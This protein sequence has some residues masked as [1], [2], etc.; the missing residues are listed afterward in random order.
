MAQ[1][2]LPKS[3]DAYDDLVQESSLGALAAI[4]RFEP[5]RGYKP[6]T[7]IASRANGQ[8]L[9]YRR[10]RSSTI[11][12]PWRHRDLAT[13][14]ERI[15]IQRRNEGL[16]TWSDAELATHLGVSVQR[17]HTCCRGVQN[18]KVL[19]LD[20]PQQQG[21]PGVGACLFSQPGIDQDSQDEQ[22]EWLISALKKLDPAAQHCLVAHYV[23]GWSLRELADHGGTTT[24]Q[25]RT[26]FSHAIQ[27]LK[28]WAKRDGL[29]TPMPLPG[30]LQTGSESHSLLHC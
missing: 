10:D 9:H 23:E 30:V 26:L 3:S 22:R 21:D 12:V 15:R 7:Y 16:P 24:R 28:A 2:Q 19:S 25:L 14:A 27:L 17:L 1:R 29:L 6:S 8:I 20:L 4:E 11:R 18:A 13:K 5:K